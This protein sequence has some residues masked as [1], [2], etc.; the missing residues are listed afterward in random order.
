MNTCYQ[1]HNDTVNTKI[2]FGWW[3]YL[4]V[5]EFSISYSAMANGTTCYYYVC[6]N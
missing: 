3:S 2:P 1:T 6:V 4:L 5:I